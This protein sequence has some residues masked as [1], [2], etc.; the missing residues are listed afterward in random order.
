[1]D[2]TGEAAYVVVPAMMKFKVH[3]KQVTQSGAVVTIALR[4]VSVAGASQR[5]RGR[6]VLPSN[7]FDQRL[8]RRKGLAL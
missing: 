8:R 5:G 3:G 7:R 1:M 2:V 4:R 6:K